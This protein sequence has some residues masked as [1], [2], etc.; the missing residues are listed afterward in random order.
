MCCY[1]ITSWVLQLEVVEVY[2]M[3]ICMHRK[4]YL[5]GVSCVLYTRHPY[6]VNRPLWQLS[7]MQ[8]KPYKLSELFNDRVSERV[9]G[10]ERER[11]HKSTF[12]SLSWPRL[13]SMQTHISMSQKCAN[14]MPIFD[15]LI[16][17]FAPKVC[18]KGEHLVFQI[19]FSLSRFTH[20]ERPGRTHITII[21]FSLFSLRPLYLYYVKHFCQHQ[22]VNS[23]TTSWS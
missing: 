9:R 6:R 3:H 23:T 8:I 21:L 14:G 2:T 16:K 22:P 4:K 15:F 13:H 19:S 1:D 7:K 12:D 5:Y 11:E 10:W 18:V 20:C 17:F